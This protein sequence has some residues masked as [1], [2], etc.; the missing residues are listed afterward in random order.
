MYKNCSTFVTLKVVQNIVSLQIT[1]S[2]FPG[3]WLCLS[4]APCSTQT[5]FFLPLFFQTVSF[6]LASTQSK[7]IVPRLMQ[8]V[9]SLPLPYL[10]PKGRLYNTLKTEL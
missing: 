9:L 1:T 6:S 7:A 8:T 2:G 5:A 3:C 4:S 10:T